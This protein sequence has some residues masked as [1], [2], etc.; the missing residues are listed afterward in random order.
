MDDREPVARAVW[1]LHQRACYTLAQ[2]RDETGI[3]VKDIP[4]LVREGRFYVFQDRMKQ[5]ARKQCGRMI[6]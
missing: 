6:Q 3:P 4:E 2:I 5:Q 1:W